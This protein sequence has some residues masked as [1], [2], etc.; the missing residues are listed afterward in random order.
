MDDRLVQR[1]LQAGRDVLVLRAY[2]TLGLSG[3]DK[4][5]S[6]V[7]ADAAVALTLFGGAVASE[8][9]NVPASVLAQLDCAGEE[10]S[11][12]PR[13]AVGS[14]PHDLVLVRV[15]VEA[16]VECDDGVQDPHRVGRRDAMDRRQPAVLGQVNAGAVGLAHAVDDDHQ[17]L[18]P[19]RGVVGGGGMSQVMIHVVN[20]LRPEPRQ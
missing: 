11:V 17:A 18:R 12:A 14:Q 4:V 16:K 3:R 13:V 5:L 7:F 15:E 9:R 19:A 20:P 6:Q 2:L 10:I 1:C 8:Q